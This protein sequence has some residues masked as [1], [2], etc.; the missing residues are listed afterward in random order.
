[1]ISYISNAK[2]IYIDSIAVMLFTIIIIEVLLRWKNGIFSQIGQGHRHFYCEGSMALE[3]EDM[4]RCHARI[5]E[6]NTH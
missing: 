2:S 5:A 3:R 6:G 1:M 4:V